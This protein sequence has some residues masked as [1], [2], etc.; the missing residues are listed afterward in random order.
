MT[1]FRSDMT[2]DVLQHWGSDE[3]AA[4]AARVSTGGQTVSPERLNGLIKYL[5]SG[6]HFAPFEHLGA[7]FRVEVPL[8]VLAQIT[9]HRHLSFSVQSG[10]YTEA[11][12]VFWVPDSER[13]LVNKGTSARP[14]MGHSENTDLH[15]EALYYFVEGIETAVDEYNALLKAGV[16]KEV[17]RAVLPQGLYTSFYVSGNLRA[18]F[19]VLK[20]RNGSHG[21]P[22]LEI[23]EVAQKIEAGIAVLFPISYG[24]WKKI[25]D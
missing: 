11:D 24:A 22:Q 9:R 18:W 20:I 19:D 25:N 21:H 10:R 3:F 4:S 2:V 6:G 5:I 1:E 13:P 8:F 17:A 7:T 12:P 23:V 15:G 16:A 14:E